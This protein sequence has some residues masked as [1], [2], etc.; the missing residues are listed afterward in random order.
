VHNK[1][2]GNLE[3]SYFLLIVGFAGFAI[4]TRADLVWCSEGQEIAV[5]S[6]HMNRKCRMEL[7]TEQ[8]FLKE[9]RV[10]E[11]EFQRREITTC[12]WMV[13]CRE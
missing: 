13:C 10:Q 8:S 7:T 5:P 4:L 11:H 3:K 1:G 2:R 6:D 9:P 12:M